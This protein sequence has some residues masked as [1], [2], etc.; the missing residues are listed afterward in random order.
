[1]AAE[2]EDR[3]VTQRANYLARATDLR[4]SEAKAVAWS[5]RGYANSTIGRKLDTSKSTAKGWLE[6]AMAQYGLE[7]AEVLSPDQLEPPLSE[8][9]YEAVDE[10]YLDELQTR[11][12]KERWAEC[13][14]RNADSLP[15]EWVNPV[16]DRLEQEGYVSIGD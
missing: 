11:A 9:A 7:I 5:E 2:S 14:E 6:R 13:V 15:A 10:S 4:K 1:M 8:P 16:L 3:R 12:D